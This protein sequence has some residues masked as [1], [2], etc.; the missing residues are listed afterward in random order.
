MQGI[1]GIQGMQGTPGTPTQPTT[2]PGLLAS[3]LA[4][5][6]TQ[7][8]YPAIDINLRFISPISSAVGSPRLHF[9]QILSASTVPLA[10]VWVILID[11]IIQMAAW[12][13]GEDRISIP[14]PGDYNVP[15]GTVSMTLSE[16]SNFLGQLKKGTWELPN[17]SGRS[18]DSN[19][20]TYKVSRRGVQVKSPAWLTIYLLVNGTAT[21]RAGSPFFSL[22]VP[23]IV[24]EGLTGGLPIL[25]LGLIATI[26]V[27]DVVPPT[28]SGIQPLEEQPTEQGLITLKTSELI[29][30]LKTFGGSFQK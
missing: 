7:L 18:S 24:V 29:N 27:R 5:P 22:F 28:S 9:N 26:L 1:Q 20:S 25:I 16:L 4:P 15:Q 23:I 13:F 3:G 19:I 30:M 21:G 6:G 10:G 17:G 14:N 12:F 8:P 11:I 2:T